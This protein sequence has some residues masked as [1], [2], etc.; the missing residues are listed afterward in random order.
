MKKQIK[1]NKQVLVSEYKAQMKVEWGGD[2]QLSFSIQYVIALLTS[3]FLKEF[4]G[5]IITLL[6]FRIRCVLLF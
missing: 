3:L 2:R 5:F 6:C 4:N 1:Y